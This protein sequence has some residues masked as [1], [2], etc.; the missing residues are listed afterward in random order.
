[1]KGSIF[2]KLKT[3]IS[4]LIV[5]G[6]LYIFFGR[7]INSYQESEALEDS[8]VKIKA[9][10]ID[11]KNYYGNGTWSKKFSYSYQFKVGEKYYKGDTKQS[12]Y[13]VGDSISIEYN[14]NNPEYNR[15]LE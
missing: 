15:P 7:F 14:A 5:G 1:M 10:V 9:V 4:I 2:E 6:V 11:E 12:S 13:S 3:I 8:T